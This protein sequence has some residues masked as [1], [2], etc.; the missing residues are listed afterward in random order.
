MAH[1]SDLKKLIQRQAFDQEHRTLI[2]IDRVNGGSVWGKFVHRYD[3]S[4]KSQVDLYFDA[5]FRALRVSEESVV[6]TSNVLPILAHIGK[7]QITIIEHTR[8]GCIIKSGDPTEIDSVIGL[9]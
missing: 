8:E 3:D 5:S 1:V 6:F 2:L 4:N 9:G 7:Y